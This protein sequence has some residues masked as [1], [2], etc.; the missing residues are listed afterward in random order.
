MFANTVM[1]YR[2]SIF[3]EISSY[4][5]C[6]LRVMGILERKQ[7]QRKEVRTAILHAAWRLV[8][9]EGWQSLSIRKVA[10]A[11]EYSVPVIYSHFENK[12]AILLEFTKEGFKLLGQAL[13][14]ARDQ[15]QPVCK[16]LDA[17]AHAYWNFAFE[18]KEYYQVMFGLGIPACE[19]VNRIAEIKALSD[20]MLSVIEDA[21]ASGKHKDADTW[22]KFHTYWSILHGLVSIQMIQNH[23]PQGASKEM[24]LQD[25][26]ASFTR[27]LVD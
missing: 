10:E 24:I 23:N 13:K 7:R 6:Q 11:I 21:V 22:L 16:K 25:A 17:M 3:I 19:T 18:N 15:E 9:K 8:I 27:S 20:V 5:G 26:I 14:A 12:D 1:F 2:I 4:S